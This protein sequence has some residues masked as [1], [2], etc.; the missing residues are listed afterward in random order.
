ML[1]LLPRPRFALPLTA[2]A[3]AALA[4]PGT[5]AAQAPLRF[6]AFGDSI[7]EGVGDTLVGENAGYPKRLENRLRAAGY[8]GAVVANEGVAGEATAEAVSR[9]D[10]ALAEGADFLLLME[11]TN[12]LS[13]RVSPESVRFNLNAIALYA[14]ARGTRVVHA[15]VIPRIP[16][17]PVDATNQQTQLLRTQIFELAAAKRRDTADAFGLFWA[18]P[19]YATRY[20]F[21]DATDPVGHPNAAGYDLL[22]GLW[23][24]TVVPL[25]DTSSESGDI[26]V[27][28]EPLVVGQKARFRADLSGPFSSFVWSFGREGRDLGEPEG[29]YEGDYIFPAA[30]TYMV[31]YRAVNEAGE[32]LTRSRSVTV[33]GSPPS[34]STRRTLLPLVARSGRAVPGALRSDVWIVNTL[35]FNVWVEAELLPQRNG[36]FRG[37]LGTPPKRSFALGPYRGL[38]VTDLLARFFD[39]AEGRGALLLTVH[40]VAAAPEIVASGRVI[41]LGLEDGPL[42]ELV[43]EVGEAQWSG[44]RRLSGLL[45][46]DGVESALHLINP[47][48]QA[49]TVDVELFAATG[50]S[51]GSTPVPLEARATVVR[52]LASLFP[53]L[54]ATAGP[55][56]VRLRPN[57]IRLAAAGE[58]FYGGSGDRLLMSQQPPTPSPTLFVP[59]VEKAAPARASTLLVFNPATETTSLTFTFLPED[60]VGG[61]RSASRSVSAGAV[62]ASDDLLLDLFGLSAGNG[63]LKIAWSNGGGV[64]PQIRSLLLERPSAAVGARFGTAVESID[65]RLL[66]YATF[67]PA[68][69][70][71]E[72][73]ITSLGL[74][75]VEGANGNGDYILIDSGSEGVGLKSRP[76]TVARPHAES[77]AEIFPALE[78]AGDWIFYARVAATSKLLGFV[79]LDSTSGDPLIVSGVPSF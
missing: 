52:T 3:L 49:G 5:L 35:G 23:F 58:L 4:L 1:S 21:V 68:G 40:A 55:L 70:L 39:I 76:L 16:T 17:A 25:I 43:S 57:G 28:T 60:G 11:G 74:M 20:Y 44:E 53:G 32:T 13:G 24:Q 56:S 59:W 42:S 78:N 61:E 29:F 31:S 62:L 47:D 66:T 33:S 67:A 2:A 38:F 18:F 30:G 19:D 75:I 26:E 14:E 7:T 65:P 64:S 15:S 79:R 45:R 51:L 37:A 8:A 69:R 36:S 73:E 6:V 48:P 10:D 12:D 34:W 50:V 22:A 63:A 41:Q 46:A 54:S 71:P 9:I 72:G 77:L 27:L